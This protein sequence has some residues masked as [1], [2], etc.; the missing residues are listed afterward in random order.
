MTFHD[1]HLNFRTFQLFHD[2]YEPC[3][4]FFLRSADRNTSLWWPKATDM[5]GKATRKTSGTERF[6]SLFSLTFDQ[7]YRITFKPMTASISNCDHMDWHIKTWHNCVTWQI[8]SGF[9]S[10]G[11]NYVIL[12][13]K[14]FL[15]RSIGCHAVYLMLMLCVMVDIK[16]FC[17]KFS[18]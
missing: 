9:N 4:R 18:K 13:W 12:P 11:T 10:C 5:R 14:I 6:H 8:W 15:I 16:T 1:P 7:F 17:W 2:F 3:Q